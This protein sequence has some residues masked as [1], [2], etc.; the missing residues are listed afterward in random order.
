MLVEQESQLMLNKQ[1]NV[2]QYASYKIVSGD[3]PR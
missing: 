3:I 1:H 2:I